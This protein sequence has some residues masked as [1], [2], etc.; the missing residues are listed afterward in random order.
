[1][2]LPEYVGKSAYHGETAARYDEHRVVE[3][4][5]TV[6]QEFVRAWV[7]SLPVGSRILDLPAGTGRFVRFYAERGLVV[8]LRDISADM[9][10]EIDG[11]LAQGMDVRVGDAERIDLAPDA[12]DFVISWRFFHL[13]PRELIGRVLLEFVR[14]CRGTLVIQ[15]FSVRPSG[16]TFSPWRVFKDWA[17]PYWRRLVPALL[18]GRPQPWEHITSFLHRED[19]L[20]AAFAAAGLVIRE[21][22]TL[23]FQNELANR[24]Y[25]LTRAA[26]RPG[27]DRR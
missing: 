8:H 14:V 3:P 13:I 11:S 20:I 16:S 10:A 23:E 19:D 26:A 24:V 21:T 18:R 27:D 9:L 15:V 5:W 2:S 25:F 1:M 17:R 4:I 7:Q 22:R 12:V 6:E